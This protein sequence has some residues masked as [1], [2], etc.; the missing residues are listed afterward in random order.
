MFAGYDPFK[1]LLP[2]RIYRLLMPG[3]LHRGV[4]RLADLLPISRK[5]MSFDFKLKRFLAGLSYAPPFW[6]PVWLA[7]IEPR[8]MG[9]FLEQPAA[10]ADVY[11]EALT[12]YTRFY[13]QD[14]VLMKVDRAAMM[15]G[16]ETRAAFLDNDLVDFCA[17]LPS[18]FKFRHGRGKYL[19][20]RAFRGLIPDAILERHKKGFGIPVSRWLRELPASADDH[21]PNR[22]A[23]AANRLRKEHLEGAGE[24]RL[25][26]WSC[27]SLAHHLGAMQRLES[28][29]MT[30][31]LT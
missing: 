12:F 13:L 20:R 5:N 9:D 10:V 16:L 17:R 24:H 26:L 19:L 21:L 6:N 18:R 22:I 2:A 23:R 31:G 15:N 8:D 4:R 7:P 27:L 28:G 25:A 11:E 1:A 30:A 3:V 29:S 14:D